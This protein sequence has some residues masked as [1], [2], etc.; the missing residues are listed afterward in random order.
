MMNIGANSRL[1][2]QRDSGEMPPEVFESL[3]L[4]HRTWALIRAVYE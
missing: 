4:E 1:R 3:M 2:A